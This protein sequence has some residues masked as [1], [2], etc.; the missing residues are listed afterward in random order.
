M[1]YFDTE[2][3]STICKDLFVSATDWFFLSH[4]DLLECI[5]PPHT[6]RSMV[7]ST[8]R[9]SHSQSNLEQVTRSPHLWTS[10]HYAGTRAKILRCFH[11]GREGTSRMRRLCS[12][13]GKVARSGKKRP[14]TKSQVRSCNTDVQSTLL[15]RQDTRCWLRVHSSLPHPSH[16]TRPSQSP[17][18]LGQMRRKWNSWDFP[19]CPVVRTL[20][21][22]CWGH[23]FNP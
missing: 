20:H 9:I 2:W 22:H 19:G 6:H 1:P 14:V 8:P 10:H 21:F 11:A 17:L 12:L 7:A 15:C 4:L 18:R 13:F 3:L 23:A 16:S 5:W